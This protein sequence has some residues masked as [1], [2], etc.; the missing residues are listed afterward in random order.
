M[1]DKNQ[2]VLN[3]KLDVDEAAQKLY[4][5]LQSCTIEM[6]MALQAMGKVST[7]ALNRE[8]LVSLEKE[9]AEFLSVRY[10]MEPRHT[11]VPLKPKMT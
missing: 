2:G 9:L 4:N 11:A 5:F 1:L 8:D 6:K 7:A 10:A 3:E